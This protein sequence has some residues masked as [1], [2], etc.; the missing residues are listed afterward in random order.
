MRMSSFGFL[1]HSFFPKT[2]SLVSQQLDER[3]ICTINCI[4]RC[5]QFTAHHAQEDDNDIYFHLPEMG[6][7][8]GTALDDAS[9]R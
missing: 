8:T 5:V 9:Q 3:Q 1:L 6:R 2:L 4:E 7:L